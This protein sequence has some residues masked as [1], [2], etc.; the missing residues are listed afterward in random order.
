MQFNRFRFSELSIG[1]LVEA[2]SRRAAEIPHS[3]SW[4]ARSRLARENRD[5]L[6][7]FHD[8]HRGERCFIIG[9]GPSLKKMDLSVLRDEYSFGLNRIY[10]LFDQIGYLPP[11][12]VCINEL[13]LEQFSNEIQEYDKPKFLNWNRRTLFKN[14]DT[15]THFVKIKLAIRDEFGKDI[16]KPISS[17]GTVT[18]AAMQ[19]AYFMGFQTVILIGVDHSYRSR[20]IPNL[21]VAR[22]EDRDL[23]HF[24]PEYFPKGSKW[25]PPDLVRSEVAYRL[26]RRAYEADSRVILDAT[27]NGNCTIFNKVDFTDLF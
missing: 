7:Q 16:L 12:Y 8:I 18:Y 24:H 3:L 5:Q 23:D 10:L 20:G 26:A 11:Y 19:I 9:N 27:V 15:D 6:S 25:Q 2:V 4:F 17:G 13:V 22:S 21:T 1:R 14:A